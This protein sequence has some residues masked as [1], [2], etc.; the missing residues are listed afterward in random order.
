[1][2]A[3]HAFIT[4]GTGFLGLNLVEQLVDQGWEVT[5]LHRPGSDLRLISDFEVRL[6]EGDLLDPAS[7]QRSMPRG[8]DTV[9][10][11]AADITMWSGHANRQRRVN[12]EGTRNMVEV[13]LAAGAGRFVHT[14][15]QN[16][17]GLA[18][19]DLHEDLPQLGGRF[20]RTYD[21]TKFEGE[22][23]VR[24]G[25]GRGL[26]AVILNPAHILGRYDR[27]G[28]AR[29]I[30]LLHRRRLPG[31]P[32]GA[33]TFCHAAEVAK[34]HI[35]AAERGRTGRNYLMSGADATFLELFRV[36][37]EVSGCPAPGRTLPG[38][39]FRLAG[40]AGALW[41]AITGREPDI[42]PDGVAIALAR[43]R[44][45]S[46]RAEEELGYR[47]APLRTMVEDSYRWLKAEGLLA[48]PG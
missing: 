38:W 48:G 17:Y 12:V 20:G 30:R 15:T 29:T 11:V 2:P 24:D 21:R 13:A 18:Q 3:R 8:V 39:T 25:I 16:T 28:W 32:P 4:G 41:G 27:R 35:A 5:A 46:H 45:V 1:M 44:V 23:V 7:L 47:P 22:E 9:F 34:A 31:A 42:T 26:D 10:H 36:I 40:R 14:S 37:G 33:G 6:V 43:A 19:G